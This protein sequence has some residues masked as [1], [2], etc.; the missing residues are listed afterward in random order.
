MI[1]TRTILVADLRHNPL[2][3]A[4]DKGGTYSMVL[5]TQRLAIARTLG[6]RELA[7]EVYS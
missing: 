2:R 3:V 6:I 7:C 5:G 1:E 4:T